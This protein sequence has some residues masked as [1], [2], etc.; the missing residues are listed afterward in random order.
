MTAERPTV[1][2]LG[3]GPWQLSFLR[4]GQRLGLDLFVLDGV[5]H[6]PGLT[7]G[8]RHAVVDIGDPSAV[9]RI[10]RE[11]APA[12]IVTG[13]ADIG[14]RTMAALGEDLPA[15]APAAGDW[16]WLLQKDA[17]ALRLQS[18]GVRI[19]RHRVVTSSEQAHAAIAH[20]GLPMILK[21]TDGAGGR[22]VMRVDHVSDVDAAFAEAQA[23]ARHGRV[24]AEE[25]IV[26]PGVGYEGFVVDGE[27]VFHA[28]LDESYGDGSPSPCGHAVP[29]TLPAAIAQRCE[30]LARAVV[31][32]LGITA[33]PFNLD[34]RLAGEH[35]IFIEINPRAGGAAISDLLRH[36]TGFDLA[37]A[38][39]ALALGQPVKVPQDP[40]RPM[41]VRLLAATGTGIVNAASLPIGPEVIDHALFVGPGS[42]KRSAIPWVGWVLTGGPTTAAAVV[43]AAQAAAR[44][45]IDWQPALG[46]AS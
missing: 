4:A 6:A 15:F 46:A 41:A 29:T 2:F 24:L 36:A 19:P 31:A 27:I 33:G 44:L 42:V 20:V 9:A 30:E 8:T 13:G 37:E 14:V 28:V 38:L 26:G 23:S 22:G 3:A 35:P 17:V 12:A 34:L 43:I 5:A 21:P 45:S 1:M 40:V 16:R 11:V 32:A 10:A 7:K 39:F 25:C 18:A